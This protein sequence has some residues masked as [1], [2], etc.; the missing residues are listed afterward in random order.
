LQEISLMKRLPL[1]RALCGCGLAGL[2]FLSGA[3]SA[4]SLSFSP[5]AQN[6]GLGRFATVEV[7]ITD[8][9]PEPPD[10]P[11]GLGD[12]DFEVAYDPALITFDQA[13]DVNALGLAIGVDAVLLAPGRL[14]L[15][16]FSLEAPEDLLAL[17]SDSMLLLTLGFKG[18]APGTS[19]LLFENVI[20][21][22]VL[23]AP[24]TPTSRNGSITVLPA[25]VPEPGTLALFAG[26]GLML[27][28]RLLV[29]PIARPG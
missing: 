24:R 13:T 12:F 3:A 27:I 29:R 17:Q 5:S 19:S 6:V 4:Y 10:S 1:S 2:L 14:N 26:V 9:A 25:V 18:I 15:S 20:L 23:G 8:V 22:D 21:G 11:G 7:R 16:A 28:L